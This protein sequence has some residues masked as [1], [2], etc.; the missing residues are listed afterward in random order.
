VPRLRPKLTYNVIDSHETAWSGEIWNLFVMV[1]D[2]KVSN[3][4]GRGVCV[5]LGGEKFTW[6]EELY[7]INIIMNNMNH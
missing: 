3:T 2:D 4:F 7:I 5:G 6:I 1:N